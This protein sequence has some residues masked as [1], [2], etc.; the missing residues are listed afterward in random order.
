M[1]LLKDPSIKEQGLTEVILSDL[2]MILCLFVAVQYGVPF[3]IPVFKF[4]IVIVF[5]A[6]ILCMFMD[7]FN[8]ENSSMFRLEYPL[9]VMSSV[10]KVS[11]FWYA[12]GLIWYTLAYFIGLALINTA[13]KIS[14]DKIDQEYTKSML[15]SLGDS[16]KKE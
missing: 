10:V 16:Q 4:W 9:S 2:I 14:I 7:V 3:I 6:G 12:T 1:S 5:I 15:E 11:A 8:K 13:Y